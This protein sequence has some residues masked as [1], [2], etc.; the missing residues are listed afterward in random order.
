MLHQT[1]WSHFA[2]QSSSFPSLHAHGGGGEGEGGGVGEA[3]GDGER[4]GIVLIWSGI[5]I[6]SAVGSSEYSAQHEAAFA[7]SHA[8]NESAKPVQSPPQ[9]Q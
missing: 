9:S 7:S 4:P 3:D 8:Q 6:M 5:V 2:P 1:G